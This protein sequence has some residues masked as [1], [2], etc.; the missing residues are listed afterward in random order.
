VRIVRKKTCWYFFAFYAAV[1]GAFCGLEID[2]FVEDLPF[3]EIST[4]LLLFNVLFVLLL[5][6]LVYALFYAIR[7]IRISRAAKICMLLLNSVY[8]HFVVL[9]LL[10]KSARDVDFDFYFFWYNTSDALPVLWKIYA[11]GLIAVLLSIAAFVLFQI[12]A[13]SPLKSILKNTQRK[14]G[15]VLAALVASSVLCQLATLDT[16]RG[17][18]AG[19][20]YANFLSDRQL[21]TDYRKFYREHIAA[22]RKNAPTAIR[23]NNAALTDGNIFFVKLESLNGL[24]AGS[25]ITPHLM[26]ASRDGVLFNKSYANSIQSLRGYECIL[27]GVPPNLSG[28]LVDEYAAS[29]LSALGCLPRLFREQGYRTLYFFGGSRNPRI[30]RF[31]ESI[32]FEKVLAD[33]IVK[34]GDIKYDWGYREDIFYSRVHEY[35][36]AHCADEKLFVFIDTGA[37]NHTPFEVLD[38]ALRQKVPFPRPDKFEERISNTTFV[39]DA[40]FGHFYDIFR[41]CYAERSTLV[42]ASDHSWPIPIHRNNIYNERGAFEENFLISMLFIPPSSKKSFFATGTAVEQRFSQ[43]DIFPTILDLIGMEQKHL[44]GESFVPWLLKTGAGKSK[45]PERIK[46]SIQPYGGGF[47]S[48]VKYPEKYLFDT[49]GKNVKV[50]NLQRDPREQFPAVRDVGEYMFLIREFFQHE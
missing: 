14:A 7:P 11:P 17:S 28:A 42:A 6:S 1:V 24:L 23:E 19:F 30:R 32:G 36:Q 48:A 33:D 9:L 20:V 49:L 40:Y 21:R 25:K 22:L 39:Q 13:F 4:F 37:T 34:P 12:P 41:K 46:I 27:C 15:I 50:F 29:E 47:I 44:R 45:K 16:I 43:M 38:D 31:A 2:T 18:T 5:P 10:Y 35:I 26:R 3:F 8:V